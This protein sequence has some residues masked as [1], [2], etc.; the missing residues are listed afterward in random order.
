MKDE[1]IEKDDELLKFVFI[2]YGL[3]NFDLSPISQ[4]QLASFLELTKRIKNF[5]QLF[6]FD[7]IFTTLERNFL[8]KNQIQIISFPP[9]K[10]NEFLLDTKIKLF[11]F[12]PHCDLILYESLADWLISGLTPFSILIYGNSI[13]LY[14]EKIG[15]SSFNQQYP[16]ISRV[17]NK[18][19]YKIKPDF[20]IRQ[21]V[22]N[23]CSLYQFNSN[24]NI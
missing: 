14:I 7:P 19:E 22:F 13:N 24:L 16:N 5:C 15:S 21:D 10:L 2:S 23:D 17:F 11:F 8:L 9:P 1:R 20:P 18:I 4:Y 3:G 6:A 12:M